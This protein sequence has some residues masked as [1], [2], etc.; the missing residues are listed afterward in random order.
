MAT[1]AAAQG[2]T[3][4]EF[5]AVTNAGLTPIKTAVEKF[6][7]LHRNDRPK[8]IAQYE[9]ALNHLVANLPRGVKFV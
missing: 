5:Q 8:T 6:L 2:L 3:I 1:Q 7:K 9:G 4:T